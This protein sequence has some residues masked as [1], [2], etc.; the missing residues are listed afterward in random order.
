MHEELLLEV[1]QL[2]LELLDIFTA[3]LMRLIFNINI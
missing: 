1:L 3:C 2:D